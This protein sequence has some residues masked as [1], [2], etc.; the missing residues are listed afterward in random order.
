MIKGLIDR[1]LNAVEKELG[2]PIDE[3]RYMARHNLRALWAFS[4][5][6]DWA[7]L[8]RVLPADVYYVAKIAAYRQ[9]D[10]GSCLQIAVNKAR[11]A[12]IPP[13]IIRAA[14][15]GRLEALP[16][17]LRLVFRFAEGQANREDDPQAREGIIQRYGH[18][19]LIELALAITSARTFPTLKRS[20]GFAISCSRVQVAV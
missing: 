14:A 9:E 20:L 6:L 3:S 7:E 15:D 12:N 19:G 8:R 13:A 4:K 5:V 1:K 10:C 16:P 2:V 17:E 11:K 18:D